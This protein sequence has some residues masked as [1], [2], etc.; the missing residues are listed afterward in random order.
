[1]TPGRAG[2]NEVRIGLMSDTH[3]LLRPEAMAALQGVCQILH[4]GDVCT[5]GILSALL[6]IAPV[7]AVRGNRDRG[8]WAASLPLTLVEDIGRVRIRV[9]HR[10]VDL[11]ADSTQDGTQV[12]VSGHSHQPGIR[13]RDGVIY[14]NPGSAGPR[15]FNLPVTLAILTVHDEEPTVE[16]IDLL[17]V[18]PE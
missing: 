10:L 11:D 3:N 17:P 5:P 14:V 15:R 12:V 9:V 8:E 7:Q 13:E 2:A 4:A 1:M 18:R 16:L 6:K